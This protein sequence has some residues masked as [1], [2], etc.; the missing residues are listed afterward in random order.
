MEAETTS[1]P[2]SQ[3]EAIDTLKKLILYH[4]VDVWIGS[5]GSAL[6]IV[7][8]A[9]FFS[10]RTFF[11]QNMLLVVLAIGDFCACCGVLSV[12]LSRRQLYN[13]IL[14]TGKV[15]VENS[16]SCAMKPFVWLRLLGSV[17]PSIAVLW[18]SIERLLAVL[19]PV[20]YRNNLSRNKVTPSVCIFLY[21]A[22]LCTIAVVIAFLNRRQLAVYYCGRKASFSNLLST[23]IYSSASICYILSLFFNVIAL[24]S[25]G[26]A[27]AH[28]RNV[29]EVQRQL[30]ILRY[31][32]IISFIS[33]IVILIPNGISIFTVIYGR[34]PL[35]LVE[36]ASWI[37]AL[38]SSL[39]LFV[40]LLLKTDF[41][42]RVYEIITFN[43]RHTPS[44]SDWDSPA[45]NVNKV[46]DF[47]SRMDGHYA[48]TEN[49]PL[50]NSAN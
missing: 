21:A 4:S 33:T 29:V 8:L 27:Y 23:Y 49:E 39:N 32:V 6:N 30:R 34:M 43:K 13:E 46:P 3:L 35:T 48:N 40:Y 42:S 16:W 25:L 18:I 14:E 50:T 15:P 41:R 12:G 10:K 9:V 5:I 47:K 17:V 36:S 37:C 2:L 31:L 28:R 38:K 19:T 22:V 20:F 45:P 44:S 11:Q 24:I 26:N 7:L 1:S